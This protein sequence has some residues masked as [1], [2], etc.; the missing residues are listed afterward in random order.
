LDP[1]SLSPDVERQ[2]DG[3]FVQIWVQ[4][5]DDARM[6]RVLYDSQIIYISYANGNQATRVSYV[7]RLVRSFNLLRIME[8]TRVIWAVM[9]SS[10]RLKFITPV[11]GQSHTRA[12]Q[13]LAQLMNK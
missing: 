10:Y 1:T 7:E 9:N 11:G 13:S 12:K 5:P 4:F 3:S 8:T 6:R 2:P